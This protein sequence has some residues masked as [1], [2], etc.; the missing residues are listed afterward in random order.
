MVFAQ[1]LING[2]SYG[3]Q[4]FIIPL[5][6]TKTEDL[7][8]G[9]ECG[10]IGPKLGHKH[11]DQGYLR[12]T[13]VRI[14][15]ENLLCRFLQVAKGGN[16]VKTMPKNLQALA[17]AGMLNL[18]ILLGKISVYETLTVGLNVY[19]AAKKV[20]KAEKFAQVMVDKAIHIYAVSIATFFLNYNLV[21]L[22][23]QYR[24]GVEQ[25]RQDKE[26]AS[27]LK[28]LHILASG[29]KAIYSYEAVSLM[30]L[31]LN[32]LNLGKL[33]LNGGFHL[34]ATY[35]PGVTYEGD[36]SVLLQQ[37]AREILRLYNSPNEAARFSSLHYFH[38]ITNLVSNG[39]V[40]SFVE[41]HASDLNNTDNV[42]KMLEY[43]HYANTKKVAERMAQVVGEK[44][45]SFLAAWN[46]ELQKDV[47]QNSLFFIAIY[48]LKCFR[49]ELANM[50]KSGAITKSSIDVLRD[51]FLV[52]LYTTIREN[53]HYLTS[54]N[55]FS[56]EK[57]SKLLNE[58]Q[59]QAYER[60]RAR[61]DDLFNSLE[62]YPYSKR[63]AT[64][65]TSLPFQKSL[66]DNLASL[67][68]P[69]AVLHSEI[70]KASKL[71]NIYWRCIIGLRELFA[72]V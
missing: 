38:E 61:Q 32:S 68:E 1:T 8:P 49:D 6:D 5:R 21:Q 13:N 71:Q 52:T 34:Y 41:S 57:E 25:N 65:F 27:L 28:E 51:I 12:L 33:F 36:N 46:E 66:D 53:R 24:I 47:I 58:L 14:P 50:T 62:I 19:E 69:I 2:K 64:D 54:E 16:E 26:F 42:I 7:L 29:Y 9:I 39:G 43:A 40:K 15:R 10:D 45:I 67:K 17:Y 4:A 37:T 59:C 48:R 56:S 72:S 23:D 35:L 44:G 22:L 11:N 3:V 31:G 18:R 60:L 55:L 63:S 20:G 30:R 70:S